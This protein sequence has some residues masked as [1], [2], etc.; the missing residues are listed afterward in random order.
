MVSLR[1]L[2]DVSVYLSVAW[3]IVLLYQLYYAVPSWLFFSVVVGWLAYLGTA[4]LVAFGR[5]MAYPLVLVLA[6]L[7]LAVSLPQPEHLA[8][9]AAGLSL[10]SITFLLGSALQLILLV[11]VPAYLLRRRNTARWS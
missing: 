8:F 2:I 5:R 10:A 7:T 11:L 9:V 4:V 1:R 6:I 3:G